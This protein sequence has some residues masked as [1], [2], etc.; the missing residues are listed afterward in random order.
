MKNMPATGNNAGHTWNILRTSFRFM[1][2]S[3]KVAPAIEEDDTG[4]RGEVPVSWAVGRGLV[5]C[6]NAGRTFAS[7]R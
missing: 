4:A 2:C 1:C 3:I 5:S 6:R 7:Q